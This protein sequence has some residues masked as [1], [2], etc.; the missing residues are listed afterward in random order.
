M[1]VA[2]DTINSFVVLQVQVAPETARVHADIQGR[3][4]RYGGQRRWQHQEHPLLHHLLRVNM[5]REN[6]DVVR[7][8][9]LSILDCS[10]SVH[11]YLLYMQCQF[12]S[13]NHTAQL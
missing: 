9:S 12:I 10:V 5:L 13:Q 6:Q 2:A 7:C 4:E 8:I 11:Y 1:I 3:A